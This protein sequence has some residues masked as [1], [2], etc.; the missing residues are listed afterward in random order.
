METLLD[1]LV[2]GIGVC[3]AAYVLFMSLWMLLIGVLWLGFRVG[4]FVEWA[5]TPRREME[6]N[7]LEA[8]TMKDSTVYIVT[9]TAHNGSERLVTIDKETAL[10]LYEELVQTH[11]DVQINAQRTKVTEWRIK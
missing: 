3:F 8:K 1:W 10:D 11:F 4:E 5:I 6:R 7:T 2:I 9:G